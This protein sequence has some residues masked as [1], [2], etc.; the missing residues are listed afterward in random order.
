MA[1]FLELL[2]R[3][4]R[5]RTIGSTGALFALLASLDLDGAKMPALGPHALFQLKEMLVAIL[6]PLNQVR[7]TT[8]FVFISKAPFNFASVSRDVCQR[9]AK[10]FDVRHFVDDTI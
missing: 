6:P 9:N 8:Y 5:E 10:R 7:L 3:A 2:L 4:I 1:I